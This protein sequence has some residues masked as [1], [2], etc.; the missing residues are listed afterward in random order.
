MEATYP[1]PAGH[2]RKRLASVV[3]GGASIEVLAGL[4]AVTLAILGLAGVLS[5][6]TLTIAMIVAGAA[7]FI[8]GL[9]VGG[10]YRELRHAHE[11]H[12]RR[13]DLVQVRTGLTAQALGGA[14][15]V[16]L[17]ILALLGSFTATWT[18]I[19]IIVLGAALLIGAMTHAELEW[20]A[21]ALHDANDSSRSAATRT[22]RRTERIAAFGGAI[23]V[24]LGI[25]SL[26]AIAGTTTWLAFRL[27]L[28]ALLCVGIAELLDG[29]AVIGRIATKPA[30]PRDVREHGVS[31]MP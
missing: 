25:L 30:G 24:F 1:T 17:G 13:S 12:E 31:G 15:V 11:V 21:V 27:I 29:A 5:F 3:G 8:D 14:V 9:L 28:V 10:A 18:A 23:V 20:G 16:L 2:E 6:Y 19:A 7:L 22:L 26:V 4:A